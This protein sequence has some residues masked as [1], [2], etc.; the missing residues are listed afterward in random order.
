MKN[1]HPILLILVSA[2]GYF[3]DAFDLLIFSVVRRASLSD[4]GVADAD[5]LSVG[6]SLLNWQMAGLLAGG[7]VLGMLGDR[8]GRLSVLFAS[9]LLYSVANIANG[10]VHDLATYRAL[11]LMAGF[12]LAGEL[13][14]GITLVTEAMPARTR[15]FGTMIVA[16]AG[17]LG[18]ATAAFVGTRLPWRA[19]FIAGGVMGLILLVSRS[20]V[21]ESM[22]YRRVAAT[23]V[24]RG[25]FISLFT[26]GPRLKRYL[27]CIGAGVPNYFVVGLLVTGAPEFGTLLGLSTAPVA[28]TAILICYLSMSAGDVACSLLSQRLRSR[29]LPP[30]LFNGICLTGIL[31]YLLVPS[32]TLAG[33]YGRCALMGFGCGFW[34]LVVT[35]AAEQF[36]TEL[37]ATVAITVPNFLRAALIPITFCYDALMPGA[38]AIGAAAIVGSGCA[39]LA[40]LSAWL[41]TETFGTDLDFTEASRAPVPRGSPASS[42]GP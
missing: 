4:L 27:L 15:G 19:A 40:M 37:R 18:A 1:R 30:I 3:V 17:L 7:I 2:L 28:G 34:A 10:F 42:T 8:R 33:F 25:R 22:L 32:R 11:R 29:R 9:I 13:G 36:G 35:N 26:S 6:L 16:T 41:S 39:I 24:P 38:G 12:G 5:S 21:A 31:L 20:R 23:A 14:A